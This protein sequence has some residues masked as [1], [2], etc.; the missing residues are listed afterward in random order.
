MELVIILASMVVGTVAFGHH[1]RRTQDR[2]SRPTGRNLNRRLPDRRARPR[3]YLPREF[4]ARLD[5]CQN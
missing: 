1:L 5:H 3:L 2:Q 4:F